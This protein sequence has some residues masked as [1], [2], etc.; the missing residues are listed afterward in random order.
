MST[1]C[2]SWQ[3]ESGH[4]S[5][6]RHLCAFWVVVHRIIESLIVVVARGDG[7]TLAMKCCKARAEYRKSQRLS[8]RKWQLRQMNNP[9]DTPSHLLSGQGYPPKILASGEGERQEGNKTARA[10]ALWQIASVINSKEALQDIAAAV[11]LR[12]LLLSSKQQS[13]V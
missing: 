2:F 11:S 13:E 7:M 5:R 10:K 4:L 9:V 1:T 12:L 6:K 3:R 8:Y